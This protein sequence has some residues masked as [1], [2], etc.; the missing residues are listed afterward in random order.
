MC[1]QAARAASPQ[2]VL[3]GGGAACGW[4]RDAARLEA[5][6]APAAR[7]L[8]ALLHAPASRQ[9]VAFPHP[10]LLQYDCGEPPQ[11]SDHTRALLL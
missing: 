7:R 5:G 9:A 4:R 1:W 2:L 10:S 6:A 11:P 8:L 3:G